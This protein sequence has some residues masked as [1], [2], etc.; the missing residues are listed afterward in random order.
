MSERQKWIDMI[1][2]NFTFRISRSDQENILSRS[3]K[4]NYLKIGCDVIKLVYKTLRTNNICG[5]ILYVAD[6]VVD[7][8]YGTAVREQIQEIGILKTELVEYNTISYAMSIAERR[9]GS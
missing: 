4:S 1:K 8:L 2:G 6:P 3:M 9:Q 7:N 5:K